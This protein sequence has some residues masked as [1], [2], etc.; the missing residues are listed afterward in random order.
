MPV[1]KSEAPPPTHENMAVDFLQKSYGSITTDPS[2]KIYVDPSPPVLRLRGGAGEGEE[3]G[4]VRL[5]QDMNMEMA[6]MMDNVAHHLESIVNHLTDV[7]MGY[8]DSGSVFGM[9]P[10]D[11]FMRLVQLRGLKDM[12]KYVRERHRKDGLMLNDPMLEELVLRFKL[13]EDLHQAHV[14][15][16]RC[17][18]TVAEKASVTEFTGAVHKL[19][20]FL[21][22]DE[23]EG[24]KYF[25]PILH[26]QQNTP[27]KLTSQVE[28]KSPA[29]RPF[30][31]QTTPS[32]SR[33]T[34]IQEEREL[35]VEGEV[36]DR[37]FAPTLALSLDE[38][39][40]VMVDR[41]PPKCFCCGKTY[42]NK[43]SARKHI[44]NN[45]CP[46][47]EKLLVEAG[48]RSPPKKKKGLL[49]ALLTVPMGPPSA[50]KTKP[51]HSW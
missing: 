34:R 27:R 23:N 25:E 51:H 31:P 3:E 49:P 46:T 38:K 1:V 13:V 8:E 20:Y 12:L 10:D 14:K 47:L 50:P 9:S 24:C 15:E 4:Y 30:S 35:E 11:E 32:K 44:K 19:M 45:P 42:K 39:L 28:L 22:S 41:V 6:G 36:E 16:G 7:M 29:V 21:T 17:R 48:K 2:V 40:K 43:R 26:S 5:S 33:S 18:L 37:S